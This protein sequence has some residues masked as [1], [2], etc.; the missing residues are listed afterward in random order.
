[1]KNFKKILFILIFILI[2]FISGIFFANKQTEPEITSTLIQN[3]IEQASDLVTTKYHYTKVGKFENSLNL[4]G[5]S[6]P[7]TNKYFI[8]TF[9]GEIQLGTDL[10]KANIEISDST[11]HVTVNKPTVISN[12]IDESSIEVYDETKNIF[13]PISV[14]DYKA[15]AVEQKEKALSEAKKKGLMKTAQENTKK[16]I[17]QIIS[18]IPDT[19]DYN[20]EVTFKE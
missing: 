8:L 17:K 6:I 19:D 7:L 4:N 13:N 15:F 14:S 5:W 18:I 16:S 20:I 10:S 3:R 2:A 11:I 1:M 12:S 9:E